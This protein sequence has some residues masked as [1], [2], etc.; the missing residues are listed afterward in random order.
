MHNI[1]QRRLSFYTL[2]CRKLFDYP[3][4]VAKCKPHKIQQH[5]GL[6]I[7][8]FVRKSTAHGRRMPSTEHSLQFMH[9]QFR[10]ELIP[11]TDFSTLR[12][13]KIK[14]SLRALWRLSA[15][16]DVQCN[17]FLTSAPDGQ[18]WWPSCPGRFTPEER[19]TDT[20]Q[21]KFRGINLAAVAAAVVVRAI[22]FAS[23]LYWYNS[24][25]W[26]RTKGARSA[27]HGITSTWSSVNSVN[28]Y[29]S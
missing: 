28:V 6:K 7:R 19:T 1:V 8:Y 17:T 11:P 24:I 23:L 27:L 3:H 12:L 15:R 5:A 10:P 22:K 29:N 20:T 18:E 14:L 26:N 9:R 16:A 21:Q 2:S 4:R 25:V 13:L